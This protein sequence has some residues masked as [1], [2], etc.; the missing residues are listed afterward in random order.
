MEAVA[1][2]SPAKLNL[3]FRVLRRRED[4]YHEIASLYQAV[5]LGDTLQVQLGESQRLTCDDPSLPCDGSNLILKAAQVF[6]R[7]TGLDLK[8]HFHLIK[9]IPIQSGLGGGSGNA[10]T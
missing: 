9:R 10:A 1:L 6:R 5:N 3:F 7:N 2:F 4:G 8:A